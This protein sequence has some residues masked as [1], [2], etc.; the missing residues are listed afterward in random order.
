MVVLEL[1]SDSEIEQS[2]ATATSISTVRN[3]IVTSNPVTPILHPSQIL[4]PP[5]VQPSQTL[6][7]PVVQPSQ[8]LY[9]HRVSQPLC[10]VKVHL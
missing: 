10:P 3:A 6:Q 5:V 1:G 7:P 2:S 4:E 9:S 8:I